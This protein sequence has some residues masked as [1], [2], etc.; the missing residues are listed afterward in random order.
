[1]DM[2][3]TAEAHLR[4]FL[5]G[6]SDKS[7]E[8]LQEI[9]A[10]L[11]PGGTHDGGHLVKNVLENV[12]AADPLLLAATLYYNW[13]GGKVGFQFLPDPA[14]TDADEYRMEVESLVDL[15]SGAL[16]GDPRRIL[17]GDDRAFFD[18]LTALSAAG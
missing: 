2:A 14:M 4:H 8:E 17:I 9:A 6:N 5:G 3:Q 16:D 11:S 7:P 10:A 1:M 18:S 12:W 15:I 13:P